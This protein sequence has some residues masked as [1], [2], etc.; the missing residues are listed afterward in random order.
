MRRHR[1]KRN[2]RRNRNA[3]IL[4]CF[5]DG[6]ESF[7]RDILGFLQDSPAAVGIICIG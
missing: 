1:I 4:S 5:S 7:L 3:S 6:F 2:K